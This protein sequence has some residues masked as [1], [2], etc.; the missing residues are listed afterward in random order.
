MCFGRPVISAS[1]PASANFSCRVRD[2]LGDVVLAL[3]PPAVEQLG[4]ALVLG[5]LQVAQAEVLELPL[6]LPHAEP[7]GQRGVD[8][9]AVPGDLAPA[10]LVQALDAAHQVQALGQHHQHHA[11]VLGDA[12]QQPAQVLLVLILV[13]GGDHRVHVGD[14]VDAREVRHHAGDAAGRSAR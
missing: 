1:I 6:D 11:H 9:L 13:L 7:V 4:D 12:E 3:G 2:D 5:G 14:L 8:A 10:L